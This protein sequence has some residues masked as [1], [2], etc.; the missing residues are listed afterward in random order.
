MSRRS[1]LRTGALAGAAAV[2]AGQW[3]TPQRAAAA[4]PEPA[5]CAARALDTVVFGN[6]ASETAHAVATTLSDSVAGQ[7]GQSARVL[8]PQTPADFWGGTSAF[9]MK[10]DPQV[11]NYVSVKFWGG[12][13]APALE[14]G[15]RLQIF[16]NGEV[17]GWLD[18]GVVDSVDQLDLGPR[19]PGGFY[20]HTLPLPL[21]ATQGRT[22]LEIEIR[23]MGR[24]WAYGAT[25]AKFFSPMTTPSRAIY[26]AYTHTS[27]YFQPAADDDFG[28]TDTAATR[29]NT[30]AAQIALATTRVVNDQIKI[31]YNSNAAKTDAYALT[32]L[33]RGYYWPQ[34]PA[35]NNPQALETLCQALDGT[36]LAWQADPKVM[37]DTQGWE[38]FGR[39]AAALCLTWNDLQTSLDS[40]VTSAPTSLANLDFER[41]DSST[42]YGWSAAS[43]ANDGTFAQDA[44]VSHSG[45]ASMKATSAAKNLIVQSAGWAQVGQGTFAFSVWVKTDGSTNTAR[46]GALFRSASGATVASPGM[47]FATAATTDW[48]QVTASFAVPAGAAEYAFRLGIGAGATAH[49]DG[50]QI[51]APAVAGSAVPR[52]TAYR[53]MM[54][55]SREYWRQNQ[56]NFTNQVMYCSIGIYTCNRALM[57]LSP[58]DAWSEADAKSWIYQAV[59]LEPLA[60]SQ[61]QAGNWTWPLGHSYYSVTP[62]G[63]SREMGWVADYGETT[64]ILVR[65]YEAV[66]Q[67]AG[68]APD[69]QLKARMVTM[70]KARSWFR[71]P[72]VDADGYKTVRLESQIGWR[73]ETYPGAVVYTQLL[74]HDSSPVSAAAAFADPD[75][76]GSTQQM[77][78]DGQLAPQLDTYLG[79]GL[80][81]RTGLNAFQFVA[82]HLPAF[83]ALPASTRR[84]PA[85]SWDT[86]DFVFTDE[87]NAC[88]AVKRGQEI[89]Y[90]S[91]YFRARQ[92]VNDMSRVHLLSP[93]SERSATVR[94][95]T[96]FIKDPNSTFTIQDWVTWDFGIYDPVSN[97]EQPGGGIAP[98]GPA[99]HQAFAGEKLYLAPLPADVPA[100]DSPV[101]G[102]QEMLVGKAPFYILEYAGYIVAMNT[103]TNQTFTYRSTSSQ[104]AVNLQTGRQTDLRR[105]IQ[106]PP[107]STLVLYDA[108]C[109]A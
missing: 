69:P 3:W 40:N 101:L 105:P 64:G 59:G 58:S 91:L 28:T 60:G 48:Q 104:R 78:Q 44:T 13:Y 82:E 21:A 74:D 92:A 93:Q 2:V 67:G 103:S 38:G 102:A 12:D 25:A 56:R 57:L 47:V 108:N 94:V 66:T 81:T 90:S 54:L 70:A 85:G 20:C 22:E 106:V 17:L 77:V 11:A 97:V 95:T 46:A 73:N 88:L 8:N 53:D 62:K 27:A 98:P 6:A 43:W 75:L 63:L 37:T 89:L 72:T 19:R 87:V 7:L 16:L 1:V 68:G 14:Q 79:N 36:Y 4:A 84:L 41:G 18:Q 61:D 107:L 39:I 99:L 71:Y 15:W 45:T 34:S 5:G 32:S 30:D 65:M 86:P 31:L 52:R 24:I 29:P 33:A 51:T 96:Q 49:F 80:G 9:T 55:A 23:A 42:V 76:V 100:Q 26:R 109:R 83:Q 35:Y 10:V 50:L